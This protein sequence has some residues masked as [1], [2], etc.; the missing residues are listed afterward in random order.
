VIGYV[1]VSTEEQ[2]DSRAGLQAQRAAI[3]AEA[4]RRGW[5]HIEFIEDAGYSGKDLKRPGIVEALEALRRRD[6][7]TLVVA[8][9]DRLSRSLLDFSGLMTRATKEHWALVALDLGVDT[10]TPQGEM[11]AN[12]LA[13]FAQFERR[14][15]GERTRDALAAKREAGVVLGRRRVMPEEIRRRILA[16]RAAGRST[17]AIAAGLNADG[18]PTVHGGRQWYPSTVAK[19]LRGTESQTTGQ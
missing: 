13:T 1:R 17:P 16:E 8:K 19:A 2:A 14:L 9:L 3:L 11:M 5:R 12:V 10:T 7:R 6:A 15:I 4:E 18:V